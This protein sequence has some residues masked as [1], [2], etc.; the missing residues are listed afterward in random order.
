MS[1]QEIRD[2]SAILADINKIGKTIAGTIT[3][4][5]RKLANGKTA[6]YHQIQRWD[7]QN[8]RNM[9]FHVPAGKVEEIKTGVEKH[10]KMEA[11]LTELA[12]ADI[13]AALGAEASED[14][15]KKKRRK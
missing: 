14:S 13:R 7:K 1:I 9:T 15:L 5:T 2:R 3:V 10:K 8:K 6:V 4:K 11:L 12:A